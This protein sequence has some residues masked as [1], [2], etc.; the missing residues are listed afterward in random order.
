MKPDDP[1]PVLL[2]AQSAVLLIFFMPSDSINLPQRALL[3]ALA[4]SLQAQLGSLV[5]VLRIDEADHPDVVQSFAI[6]LMPAFVLVQRG[7]ELW[8]QQGLADER[9]LVD[10]IRRL[11]SV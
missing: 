9:T 2:S 6:T 1:H 7:I 10:L 3:T 4:D 5:R 8:R 11:L